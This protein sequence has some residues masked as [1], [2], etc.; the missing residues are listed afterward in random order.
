MVVNFNKI[1]FKYRR[2]IKKI[3]EE[4]LKK[5]GNDDMQIVVSVSFCSET[6]IKELNNTSRGVDKVTDVLSFPMLDIKYPQKVNEFMSE[7]I[8]NGAMYL[9]DIVI[10]K[11]KAIQ[12]AIE[13]GHSLKREV[14][15]LALHGF[16]H[17]LGYDHIE[18]EDEIIMQSIANQ[19][20]EE[21]KIRRGK[22][23]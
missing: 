17:I 22:N 8:P 14:S 10:C 13:F 16:L 18:K 23:V 2:L 7:L 5:T 21:L 6:E 12:Q 4:T 1:G 15:F 19:I 3:F 20:L 11:K 9:G